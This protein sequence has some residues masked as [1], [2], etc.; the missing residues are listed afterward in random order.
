MAEKNVLY[1][2]R[3][4]KELYFSDN[5]SC[6]DLSARTHT[7]LPLVTRM[8][9]ELLDEKVIVETG[10]APS[11]GGRRPLLYS[12]RPDVFYVVAVAMDQYFTRMVIMDMQRRAVTR[13]K[14]IELPLANHPGAAEML[15]ENIDVYVRESG[16]PKDNI[17]GIGVG[18]PG[19]VDGKKGVNYTFLEVKDLSLIHI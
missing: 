2:K 5:S 10:Y 12:L 4:V 7:S 11:T 16:I 9:N 17:V 13:V 14:E 19:F 15:A 18:M 3:I 6:S 8:L 1:K